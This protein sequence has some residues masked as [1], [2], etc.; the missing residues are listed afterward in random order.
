MN[1]KK[2]WNQELMLSLF[3]KES[4]YDAGVTMNNANACSMAGYESEATWEDKVENDKGEVT[5]KE[6]GYDQEI[7]EQGVKISYKEPRAKPNSLAGLAAL[8]MGSVTSTQDAALT[9]YKHK[10]TPIAVG[11]A[12]PSI[13]AEAK[14]GGIQ[15]AYKGV[16]GNSI[17]LAG[18][19]GGVVS[20]DSELMGSGSR[21]TSATAFANKI[22]ESWLKLS[23]CKVWMEDGTDIS[24]SAALVQDAEDISSATPA[25]LKA[26][27]KSFEWGF[28]NKLEGQPGFGGAGVFQD[29]DYGRRAASLK[30]TML[31]SDNTELNHFINQNPLAIEFDM[32]GALIASTGSMYYGFQLIVPRF[33]LKSAPLAKGGVNDIL[34]VEMDCEVFEDGTNAVSILEVYNAQAAYLAA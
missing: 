30:F 12:L 14:K 10:I 20:L 13:Q 5:G 9:A 29:I 8:V 24:I 31:F 1:T 32:K 27:L 22:V 26:R 23:N 3:K 18:E 21:A 34:T 17:K 28:E 6:H 33:K 16:K 4:S 7:V 11:S 25:D 19:A 2:G 15:Y